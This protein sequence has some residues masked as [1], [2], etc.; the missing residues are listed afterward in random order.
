LEAAWAAGGFLGNYAFWLGTFSAFL[1]AFYSWRLLFLTFHGKP[2]ASPKVMILPLVV[3]ALGAIF[4]GMIGFHWFV[5]E[6]RDAF[7]HD[8]ILVLADHDSIEGAHHVPFW[9]SN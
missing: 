9:V 1:T 3:L 6:G 7:W 2:R 4:A 5:G 8:S